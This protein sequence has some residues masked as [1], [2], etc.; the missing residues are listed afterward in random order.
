MA[1]IQQIKDKHYML[2]LEGKLRENKEYK[3]MSS[4][5]IVDYS[6]KNSFVYV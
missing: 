2:S 5:A 4:T 6:N 1:A 3:P